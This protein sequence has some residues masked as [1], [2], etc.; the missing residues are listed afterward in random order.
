MSKGSSPRFEVIP[1]GLEDIPEPEDLIYPIEDI[2]EGVGRMGIIYNPTAHGDMNAYK[3]ETSLYTVGEYLENTC[4]P[5]EYVRNIILPGVFATHIG[6]EACA[7]F[8]RQY[9]SLVFLEDGITFLHRRERMG[10]VSDEGQ[11]QQFVTEEYPSK[12]WLEPRYDEAALQT[13]TLAY[14]GLSERGGYG[15][16]TPQGVVDK[17]AGQLASQ[18]LG[19]HEAEREQHVALAWIQ[20]KEKF[21]A[22]Q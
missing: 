3:L 16:I 11:L 9:S 17:L 7:E 8:S 22:V 21:V 19:D 5:E 12:A 14:K 13:I 2:I 15:L 18:S 4:A 20:W 10:M 1:G 6:G